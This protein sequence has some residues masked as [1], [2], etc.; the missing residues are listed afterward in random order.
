MPEAHIDTL[1]LQ[2]ID[3]ELSEEINS[4]LGD[5]LRAYERIL[6]KRSGSVSVHSLNGTF[7]GK[8][9]DYT[10]AVRM[11]FSSPNDFLAQWFSGLLERVA[12]D[13]AKGYERAATRIARVLK[14]KLILSYVIKLLTRNFYRNLIARTRKKPNEPLWQLWFGG[15]KMIWGLF[16]APT[17][18][19]GEWTNDK[20]EIR[21]VAFDYWTI[22]HVLETGFIDPETRKILE[23]SSIDN[24][25]QFYLSVL[26]RCSLSMHEKGIVDMYIKYL[27]ESQSPNSEPF[28]I[29]ELRYAG[30]YSKHEHRLD[31]AI[32][33]SHVM[34]F[35]GIELSPS[36]THM[37]VEKVREKT[38][39]AINQELAERWEDEVQKRNKYFTNLGITTITF[40]DNDL[41]DIKR[42]F[43]RMV[44]FLKERAEPTKS[45]SHQLLALEKLSI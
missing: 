26:R 8:N 24:L 12:E 27:H 22:G 19:D 34:R 2:A 1:T 28:L 35:V 9:N 30:L 16:I 45:L 17:I 36:S 33:N 38:Q 29:P 14:D 21:R 10:D 42:C 20:S 18:R 41:L 7:G 4:M 32:L 3:K 39:K 13:R 15:N 11:Q 31:F 5:V 44:P 37:S 40:A 25:K 6:D 23:F 43:D